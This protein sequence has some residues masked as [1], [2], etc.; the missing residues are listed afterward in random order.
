[1]LLDSTEITKELTYKLKEIFEDKLINIF[2]VGSLINKEIIPGW[3]DIDCIIVV[4]DNSTLS[5]THYLQLLLEEKYK[6]S[7]GFSIIYEWQISG[8]K[9]GGF[10][11]DNKSMGLLFEMTAENCIFG[12]WTELEDEYT[13]RKSSIRG[14]AENHANIQKLICRNYTRGGTTSI[15]ILSKLIKGIFIQAKCILHIK[16]GQVYKTKSRIAERMSDNY[17]SP[18]YQILLDKINDWVNI[19]KDPEEVH[20]LVEIVYQQITR[21]ASKFAKSSEEKIL[22][23]PIQ[24]ISSGTLT[25]NDK[26]QILFI[27]KKW[28]DGKEGYYF[29]KGKVEPGENPQH[30][31]IRETKEET[32]ATVKITKVLTP[33]SYTFEKDGLKYEK[34]VHWYTAEFL[35]DGEPKLSAHEIKT[36]LAIVWKNIEEAVDLVSEE[37]NKKLI[38]EAI[39]SRIK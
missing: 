17:A 29:P 15:E 38:I 18:F 21:N 9:S 5:S 14:L 37:E 23:N 22:M 1:M 10:L 19:T 32:G 4:K 34:T 35:E 30:A 28:D 25:F 6:I 11:M 12:E 24:K 13:F 39:E 20:H 16:E 36:Q 8:L 2:I 27:Y 31:A 26:N 3:S 33:T 7:F